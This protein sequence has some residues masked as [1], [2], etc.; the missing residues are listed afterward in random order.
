MGTGKGLMGREGERFKCAL[1][2]PQYISF[3]P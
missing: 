3:H 1:L 2:P